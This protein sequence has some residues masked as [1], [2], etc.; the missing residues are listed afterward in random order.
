MESLLWE[1]VGELADRAP[2]LT[3]LRHHK[4]QMLAASRM[5]ARNEDVPAALRHEERFVAALLLSAPAILRRVRAACDGRLVLMKGIEAGARWPHP[6]LRPAKDVDLLAEDAE[7]TQAAL[8]ADG[9]VE[10]GDP[11]L[12]VGIHHLRPLALPGLPLTIEVHCRPKWPADR[13][14]TVAEVVDAAVPCA[15]GIE[16]VLAPSAAHHAVLLAAHAWEHGP[17][18]R[19]GPLADIAAMASECGREEAAA[20]AQAWGVGRIWDATARAIDEILLRPDS[21][22]R[23]P[24]WIRHL[25]DARERTVL[26]G[27]LARIAG[28]V[29]AAPFSGAPVAVLRSVGETLRLGDGETWKAKAQRT[30]RALSN[31]SA[32]KSEHDA[33]L[34]EQ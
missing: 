29:T 22:S 30:V 3:D 17:L 7:A 9:F 10:V 8:L 20:V 21:A 31:A 26:E 12:Y 1:R 18:D 24:V 16:G 14:P 2:K 23:Q 19:I 4:L 32:P 27:H 11:K 15:A 25:G 28:P 13:A 6:R 34:I 33:T 5:R